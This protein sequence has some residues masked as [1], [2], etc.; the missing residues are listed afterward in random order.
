MRCLNHVLNIAVQAFLRKCKVLD[1]EN[2]VLSPTESED[3]DGSDS[4]LS[5]YEGDSENDMEDE[6]ELEHEDTPEIDEET[7]EAATGFQRTMW[8]LRECAKVCLL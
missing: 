5:D 4:D 7:K 3:D 6:Y 2:C 1:T 8:K